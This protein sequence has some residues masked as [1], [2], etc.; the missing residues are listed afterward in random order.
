MVWL[1]FVSIELPAPLG[2]RVWESRAVRHLTALL[3][4]LQEVEPWHL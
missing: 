3:Y 4:L 2:L 1:L